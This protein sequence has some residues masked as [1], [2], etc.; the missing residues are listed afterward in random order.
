MTVARATG[1]AIHRWWKTAPGGTA[2]CMAGRNFRFTL[3]ADWSTPSH[4]RRIEG[5][6]LLT[7]P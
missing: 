6:I 7:M 2:V 5:D 4:G 1:G 3:V